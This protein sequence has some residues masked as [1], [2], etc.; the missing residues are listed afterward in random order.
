MY[1]SGIILVTGATGGVGKRVVNLLQRKGLQVRAL[2]ISITHDFFFCCYLYL[3][4]KDGI[5]LFMHEEF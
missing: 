5:T 4:F 2:V 3:F 1:T